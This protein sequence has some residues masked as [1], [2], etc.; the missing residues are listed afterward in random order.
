MTNLDLRIARIWVAII[1][2]VAVCLARDTESTSEEA[3]RLIYNMLI[4]VVVFLRKLRM[5]VDCTLF[6]LWASIAERYKV[7]NASEPLGIQ[8]CFHF[9][10][11]V[12]GLFDPSPE[13]S[14]LFLAL[15]VEDEKSARRQILR[16]PAVRRTRVKI[17]AGRQPLHRLLGRFGT[18]L[19]ELEK[20][21]STHLERELEVGTDSI[22]TAYVSWRSM[23]QALK[24]EIEWVSTLNQHLEFDQRNN[25]L[26]V[27]RLPSLLRLLY[28]CDG[29]TLLNR[30]FTEDRSENS[31]DEVRMRPDVRSL[32]AEVILSSRLVFR[33]STRSRINL[34]RIFG[35]CN[36]ELT[37]D[38]Q[39]GWDD[40]LLEIL[41]VA[42]EKSAELQELYSD[43]QEG[44]LRDI[45]SASFF[46]TLGPRLLDLQRLSILQ[47]PRSL[48]NLWNDS[49]SW[50]ALWAAVTFGGGAL[51]LGVLQLAIQIWQTH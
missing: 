51:I 17:D 47:N 2:P 42:N 6:D 3:R 29:D 10:A 27:F 19:P 9:I 45:I 39:E 18:I 15:H 32:L 24:M 44:D 7:R 50:Y 40:P 46:P 34:F 41:S 5:D 33:D 12:T 22:N 36:N 37:K 43:L 30:L 35:K 26:R 4:D 13:S 16:Q 31:V 23:R 14:S 20:L 25:I 1:M 28:R 38:E 8:M 21:N 11:W 49:G 48:K